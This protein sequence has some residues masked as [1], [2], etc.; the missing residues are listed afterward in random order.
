MIYFVSAEN[1]NYVLVDK[2]TDKLTKSFRKIIEKQI[3]LPKAD[4]RRDW[5]GYT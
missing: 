2:S 4:N 5:N 1:S 3:P